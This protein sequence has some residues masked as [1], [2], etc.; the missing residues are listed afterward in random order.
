MFAVIM[1][2]DTPFAIVI[3]DQ[4]RTICAGPGAPLSRHSSKGGPLKPGLDLSGDVSDL[5]YAAALACAEVAA[6]S[7]SLAVSFG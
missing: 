2:G 6:S 4:Q 5:V 7:M 3:F 1:N